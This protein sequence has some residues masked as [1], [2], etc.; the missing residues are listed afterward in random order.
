MKHLLQ[1]RLLPVFLCMMLALGLTACGGKDAQPVETET[2]STAGTLSGSK[3]E[4]DNRVETPSG[5]GEVTAEVD[6]KLAEESLNLLY[7]AIA[8]DDQYA[9]AVAYLGYKEQGDAAPLSD[10]LWENCAGLVEAMPF[11]LNIPA[12]H[13]LGPGYGDL[14]CIVPRDKNTSLAVN[15]V[16]WESLGN[17][18]WPVP[19]EVLY[20]EECAQSVLIFVNYEQWRDEPDTEIVLVTNDGV[21]VKWLPLTDEY[22]I[23][24]VPTGENYLPMLMD[25]GIWGYVTGLD[26][27]EDWEPSGDDWWLPPTD[28]G[29]AYTNWTCEQWYMEF[30]WGDSDPDYSGRIDLYHQPEDGQEYAYSYSGI[31]RMEG[32]CLYLDLSDGAGT[33]MSGSFPV[34]IDPSGESLHIQQDRETGVCPPFFGEGMTCMELI[35]AYG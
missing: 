17:G 3:G 33:R 26:Y 2:G 4:K 1:R 9:G 25:F 10:W 24:I 12:E 6:P 11:L 18:V 8:F 30:G 14:F 31:W 32:D 16:T 35:R 21:E 15:H 28:W 5:S 22:G 7:D 34:L 27:P 23:P 19:G 13:I 20:R 29:L